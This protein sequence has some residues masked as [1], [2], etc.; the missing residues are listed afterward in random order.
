MA[1]KAALP[2]FVDL[3]YTFVNSHQGCWEHEDWETFLEDVAK[4]GI[5]IDDEVK[6]NLG[7]ILEALKF[8]YHAG[9]T[10]GCCCAEA[11]EKAPAKKAPAKAKAKAKA[12]AQ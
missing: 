6:R 8:F 7:N 12:K 10:C 1:G 9:L 5:T 3:A 11:A 4:T 2:G